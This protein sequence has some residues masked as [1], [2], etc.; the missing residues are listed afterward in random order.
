MSDW[1]E[2]I[3]KRLQIKESFEIPE[4]LMA[5]LIDRESREELFCAALAANP[6]TAGDT[7]SVAF[8]ENLGN[9]TDFM[10]DFTP[11]AIS[12]IVSELAGNGATWIADICAGTG[13]LTIRMLNRFP[14]AEYY[15]EELSKAAIPVLLFNLMIRN[16]SA[17][18]VNGDSLKRTQTAIYKL[19]RGE[20]FSDLTMLQ[21]FAPPKADL[22]IMNPPYSLKWEHPVKDERFEEYGLAPKSKADYAFVL[23]GL[24]MLKDSGQLLAILPH[25]VLFRSASEGDI[26]KKLIESN[27]LEL[28]IGLP[29]KMFLNTGIPTVILGIR[30]GRSQRDVLVMNAEDEFKKDGAYN[31]MESEHIDKVIQAVRNREPIEKF[32]SVVYFSEIEE[33]DFNLNIPRY[34]DTFEEVEVPDFVE[35]LRDYVDTS[36][37]IVRLEREFFGMLREMV[38][39]DEEAQKELARALKVVARKELHNEQMEIENRTMLS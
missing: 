15:L 16:V 33:N 3:K 6:D 23:H 20:E 19:T 36:I 26:R 37:E 25:G 32:A 17:I 21:E 13:S 4:K 2:V 35:T 29:S 1:L 34:V 31:R 24:H 12:T 5:C 28:V 27:L 11:D 30:K 38:G 10:Q 8:Q 39:T 14:D 9:R 22:V 18:V 7:L